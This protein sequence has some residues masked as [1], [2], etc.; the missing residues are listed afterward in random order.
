MML[1]MCQVQQWAT[2]WHDPSEPIVTDVEGDFRFGSSINL[3]GY[4]MFT[5]ALNLGNMHVF[6]QSS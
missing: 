3:F 2:I 4:R 5:C 1:G 6:I